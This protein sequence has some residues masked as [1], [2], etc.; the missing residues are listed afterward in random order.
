M[1]GG[2]L[3]V[4]S[5]SLSGCGGGEENATPQALAQ[6][7]EID[8][9][10]VLHGQLLA[11]DADSSSFVYSLSGSA[12]SQGQLQIDPNG[13]YSFTPD[14]NFNGEQ[15]FMFAATDG[16]KTSAPAPVRIMVKSRNDAPRIVSITVPPETDEDAA[17]E[18]QVEASD[19]EGSALV[20]AAA[21]PVA[22]GVLEFSAPGVFKFTPAADFNGA[23][24]F[25]LVVSDGESASVP[26][27]VRVTV[28][29]VNDPPR[30]RPIADLHNRADVYALQVAIDPRTS[31]AMS[32]P[33]K[34]SRWIRRSHAWSS[35]RQPAA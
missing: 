26:V 5:L 23:T 14:Q 24:T 32:R 29:P 25:A 15:S 22:H 28:R 27:E 18:G 3:A 31:T 6:S 30:I 16:K 33:W 34:R 11:S 21:G 12:P 8:E 9:D 19:I 1:A 17:I 2:C 10:S 4:V 20:Y 13:S 7:V 35:M